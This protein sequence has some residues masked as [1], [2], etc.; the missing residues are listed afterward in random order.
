[1]VFEYICAIL[2]SEIINKLLKKNAKI[3]DELLTGKLR[4]GK[5]IWTPQ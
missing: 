2:I 1:M 3:S 5:K 4:T